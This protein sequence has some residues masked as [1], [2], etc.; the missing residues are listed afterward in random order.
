[1]CRLHKIG[2][3]DSSTFK[4]DIKSADDLLSSSGESLAMKKYSH[5]SF[6][7]H[8]GNKRAHFKSSC[9]YCSP[10]SCDGCLKKPEGFKCDCLACDM[11]RVYTFYY[12][13]NLQCTDV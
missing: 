13:M 1:M 7:G 3:G 2:S 4:I 6:C 8:P 9:E 11:V 12:L 10:S 5:C